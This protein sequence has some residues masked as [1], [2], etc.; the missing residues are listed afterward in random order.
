[1]T[2]H[3]CKVCRVLDERG[4]GHLDAELVARWRG[5]GEARLGYRRLADWLNT[6]LLRREME[7]VGMATGG[8]EARS[9]YD[10][11]SDDDT[12]EG[13]A[14]LLR[15]GGVAVDDLRADFVSYSV[16]RT[17]L[18]DCLGE[19][20]DP[21][22][23]SDWEADRIQALEEYAADQAGDAVRSLVNKGTLDAGGEVSPSVSV[24]VTC[25]DCGATVAFADAVDA[26]RFCDCGT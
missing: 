26:E 4:L 2:D 22:P 20:R 16:V 19:E 3:G 17:H 11:L 23:P 18:R 10:R 13:V 25:A 14:D 6:T 9:R 7:R 12:A 5:D 1:M 24:T 8:G 15:R 21:A